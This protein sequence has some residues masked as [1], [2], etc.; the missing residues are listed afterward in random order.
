MS[1]TAAHLL[2]KT[3]ADDVVYSAEFRKTLQSVSTV[4]FEMQDDTGLSLG[5]LECFFP[6][7]Q[8]PADV[9]VSHLVSI[10]GTHVELEVPRQ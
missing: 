7:N 2:E 3:A 1:G 9:T 6:Q 10:A 4:K 5:T 8:T